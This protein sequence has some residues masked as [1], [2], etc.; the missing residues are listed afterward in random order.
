MIMFK[1]LPYFV[2]LG[3]R[4]YKIN[5]DF[6]K[7]ISFEQIVQDK[8]KS[9]AEKIKKGIQLFYPAFYKDINFYYLVRNPKL[10]Q[11]ACNKLVWFYKCGREDYLS[12]KSTS[13][14]IPANK[15]FSYEYDDERIYS[16]FY[17]LGID[18]CYEKVHWWKFKALLNNLLENEPFEKIKGYRAYTGDDK[19]MKELKKYYELP[20]SESEQKRLD[21]L[22]NSLK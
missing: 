11:E 20:L 18:L 13:K 1:R 17:R 2:F 8:T 12:K 19:N 10:Y 3:N 16:A 14:S 15:V 21:A 22:Y 7:M 9:K 5:V 6:R 4:K